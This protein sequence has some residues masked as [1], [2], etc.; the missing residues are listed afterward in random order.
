MLAIA[1]LLSLA[2]GTRLEDAAQRGIPPGRLRRP[3]PTAPAPAHARRH[4][5]FRQGRDWLHVQVVRGRRWWR[6]LWLWPEAWPGWPEGLTLI[7]HGAAP[8]AVY[9]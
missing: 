2:V 3:R 7:R 8:G 4:S 5:L 6:A 9:A 1:T